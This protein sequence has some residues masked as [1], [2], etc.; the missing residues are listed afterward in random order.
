M[1]SYLTHMLCLDCGEKIPVDSILMDTC[2]ACGSAWLDARYDYDEVSI[3]WKAGI[4]HPEPSLWRY[5]ALLPVEA[6]KP[7]IPM[8]E[9]YTPLYRLI[10]YERSYGHKGKLYIKDERVQPTNSFKDRQAS[11]SVMAMAQAGIKECVLASTGNAAVAYAAYC[12][13]AGIKLWLFYPSLVPAEKMRE[14]ALYG[15]EIIKV[16]GTYDETKHVAAEFAKRNKIRFDKGAKSIPGKESMKTMAYEIAEQLGLI[17]E[18]EGGKWQAPDWFVQAV[19]GGIGPIG[20]WKGFQELHQMGLIDTIPKLAIV[21]AAGCAPM[22]NAFHANQETAQAVVPQTLIHVLATGD[23]GK[24]Y[25]ILREACLS[26]GGTMVAVQDGEAFAA[27]RY[28]ASNGGISVEPATSVAFAG[29]EKLLENGTIAT[30]ET[31]VLNCSGHT[32]PVENHILGTQYEQHLIELEAQSKEQPV[33]DGIGAAL[34]TVDEKV[35]SIVVVDDN[36]G[37]RRLIQ[38][39]LQSYKRYH[40]YEAENGKEGLRLIQTHKPDLIIAD[41]MMPGMD[42]ITLIEKLKAD[43]NTRHIPVMVVT[44]KTLTDY[45]RKKLDDH[46][47]SVWQKTGFEPRILAKEI[48]QT[49]DQKPIGI[50]QQKTEEAEFPEVKL[51]VTASLVATEETEIIPTIVVVDDNP[52]D[53]RLARRMITSS[54]RKY[55]LVEAQTGR[56]G[57]K[58]IHQHH[59]DLIILDMNL[60]DISG[61]DIIQTLQEDTLLCEIPIIIYSARDLGE[62]E[63]SKFQDHIRKVISKA[64]IGRQEFL[65]LIESEML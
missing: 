24:A 56:D 29:L 55:N 43:P 46:T 39:M 50:I 11:L 47:H 17:A 40:I 23:P 53:L 58:A 48:V 4:K 52:L 21:Q 27:M 28:L 31:V 2:P 54:Q 5:Q 62:E 61:L 6:T 26:N 41:L 44:A 1:K 51:P 57:L 18:P 22:V 30:N 8:G 20:V 13:R 7:E 65:E 63:R 64:G 25:Q 19:S 37:D 34:H 14:T 12:A 15:C 10:Q 60:P 9:G 32:F 45:D 42:G 49:V 38:R 36:V 33:Q 59:P 35:K 16:S 3:L